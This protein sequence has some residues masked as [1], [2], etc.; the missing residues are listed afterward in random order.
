[1]KYS[2]IPPKGKVGEI[3]NYRTER[4]G[5]QIVVGE[6]HRVETRYH[7]LNGTSWHSYDM[8]RKNPITGMF[9]HDYISETN[10]YS[11]VEQ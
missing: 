8:M 9:F 10:L 11:K 3:W 7:F 4:R 1:M 5:H 6:I 2:W